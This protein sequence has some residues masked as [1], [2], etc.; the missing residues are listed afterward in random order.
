MFRL[1]IKIILVLLW[2]GT[3]GGCAAART[4][5]G[6]SA[7]RGSVFAINPPVLKQAEVRP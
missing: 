1:M 3:L 5:T 7:C 4:E 2:L 6:A